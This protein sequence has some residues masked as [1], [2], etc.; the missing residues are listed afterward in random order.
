MSKK[1]ILHVKRFALVAGIGLCL[2]GFV[3]MVLGSNIDT[4]DKW[5]WGTNVGW[6]NFRPVHGGVTVYLDHLEGYAWGENVCWIRM[7]SDGGGGSPYYA[8]T[9]AAN[10]GVN[11]DESGNLS[12]YAW[13]TNVGWIDFSPAHGGVTLDLNTGSFD[14]YAWGENI[15][16][17]S[18]KGTGDIAYNVVALP[19]VAIDKQAAARVDP[20]G[21]VTY[22][23]VFSNNSPIPASGV[24]VTDHMPVSVTVTSVVSG[25]AAITETAAGPSYVWQVETLDAGEGGAITITGVLSEGLPGGHVF[26]NTAEIG[27]DADAG[28]GNNRASAALT[29]SDA[30]LDVSKDVSDETPQPGDTIVYTVTVTNPG[31]DDATTVVVSD[32]VPAIL[33]SV[34]SSVSQ[35]SYSGTTWEVGGL[36]AGVSPSATLRITATVPPTTP[37]R[38]TFTN[39][40]VISHA[41]QGDSG[42]AED[43]LAQALAI[44]RGAELG[45]VKTVDDCTP[46]EGVTVTYAIT[47]TNHGCTTTVVLSDVLPAGLSYVADDSLGYDATG[48]W[49]VGELCEDESATLRITATLDAGT[50]GMSITNTAVI[51][52]TSVADP[53]PRD[54]RDAVVIHVQMPDA[55]IA[56]ATS[57]GGGQLVYTDTRG[58]TT[59]VEVSAGA[60]TDAVKVIFT[61]ITPTYSPPEGLHF[62]Q[63]VFDVSVCGWPDCEPLP[64]YVFGAPITITIQYADEDVAGLDQDSLLVTAWNGTAWEDAAC[65]PY[66]RNPG[67]NWLRVPIC[68]LTPFALSGR[69]SRTPVGGFTMPAMGSLGQCL[70]AVALL[71]AISCTLALAWRGIQE[72]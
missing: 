41:D 49:D 19:D 72:R 63:H 68:H 67:E 50:A 26:T 69:P 2:V 7:G 62:A 54:D 48:V 5:A 45:V 56:V 60:I 16:W 30:R 47:A 53:D 59:T 6:I 34:S 12:G 24:V 8:N 4:A 66:D 13:G 31:P 14:G 33:T 46:R 10:Y 9:T 38:T 65:G 70:W 39:T 35:G 44:V 40:A 43:R 51:S 57:Q 27:A 11:I 32:T 71:I 20:G 37:D 36:A 61:P 42:P 28:G 18:F 22:T 15:G 23:V 55:V 1:A 3:Q 64:N 29:V 58:L 25:G 21:T 52:E 17:I